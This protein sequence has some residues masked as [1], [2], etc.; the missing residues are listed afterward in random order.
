VRNRWINI[1]RCRNAPC[2]M[3]E[4]SLSPKFAGALVPRK[5]SIHIQERVR[6]ATSNVL[7]QFTPMRVRIALLPIVPLSQASSSHAVRP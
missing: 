5:R 2:P 3:A 6:N 7:V 4:E 1:A